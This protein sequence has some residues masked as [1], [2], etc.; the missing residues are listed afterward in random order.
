MTYPQ[1]YRRILHKMGYYSYQQGLIYRHLNQG[2]GW[3]SHEEH[4]RKFILQAVDHYK[5][6]KL[7]VLGSGWLLD[8][9]LAEIAERVGTIILTDIVHPPEV[10]SQASKM[11]NVK[12]SCEDI[13]GGLIEEVW[14]KTG[15]RAIFNKL[16][17]L[18]GIIIP[19]YQAVEDPG[20]IV[21]LNILTQLETLPERLLRKKA[22]VSEEEFNKF[23]KDVQSRHLQFLEK[24]PSVLISDVSEIFIDTTGKKE[25]KIT[26]LIDL[27][28]AKTR[29][30]WEWNFD[31]KRTDYVQKTTVLKVVAIML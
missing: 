14:R 31:I 27:P 23:R 16:S 29:E 18:D 4:C 28:A 7:T 10:I 8:L 25:E 20:L 1:S 2:D 17:T 9:P 6:R 22:R 5:P 12:L 13:T 30:E 3:V 21:S 24:H 15:K 19:G 26:A 11:K